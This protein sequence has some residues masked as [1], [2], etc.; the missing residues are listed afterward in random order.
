M[1][2]K[3]KSRR[4]FI[5]STAALGIAGA[6]GSGYLLSSCNS[7][8]SVYEAPV[9][10]SIA[11]DGPPLKAG[12]IGCGGRG[13]GA[14]IN[15]LNAGPNLEITA[16][17][18]MFQHRI[19]GCRESLKKAH[20][21]EIPDQ[22]CFIGFDAYK[23]VIDSGADVILCATPPH[24]RPAH[25][26]A[27]VQARKHCFLEKPIG[28]DPVGVRSVM[29]SGK[30][31]ASAGLTVVGGTQGRYTDNNI[32]TLAM[33]RNGA[34]GDL[35]SANA[36][37]LQGRIWHTNRQPGWSDM[38]AMMRDWINWNWL[39]GD[40]ITEM[41]I[42]R[43]DHVNWFFGK[44]P[45]RAIAL[46]GRL[47]R[48]TGDQYDFFSLDF[49]FDDKKR[50]QS[51]SRQIDGCD[52]VWDMMIFG[53]KGYT[54][55]TDRI[56]DYDDNLIWEYKYP[57]GEDGQSTNRVAIPG[58]DQ[59]MIC[60]VNAIRTNTPINDTQD[61]A[62]STLA[63]IM[64]RESAYTGKWVT[65]DDM[66]NSGQRLGPTE[67]KWGPVDLKAEHPVPGTPVTT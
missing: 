4:E 31:A 25:F 7:R 42:H 46:G 58:T 24:F 50:F 32:Q 39:S 51:M 14:A 48:P 16:L 55:G 10:P 6:I 45:E 1:N 9:F 65:W 62:S 52:N 27:A 54:N 47:H 63:C 5:T 21:V 59:E 11:P 22:N 3:A 18:D 60:L 19:D 44:Y 26:E 37:R 28:V 12:L 53:A 43:I 38:E 56:Y 67:Y 33:I 57:L 49:I 29:A 17:G 8:K 34:I 30:M 36:Y 64:G 15:F 40:Y 2:Q 23:Q 20:N 66:M 41:H 35:I 61:I 13:T